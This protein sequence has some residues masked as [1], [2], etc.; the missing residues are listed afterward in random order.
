MEE[1][2]MFK[3]MLYISLLSGISLSCFSF[4]EVNFLKKEERKVDV[5]VV[6]DNQYENLIPW[7]DVCEGSNL[8]SSD[9]T[10]ALIYAA[11][12][13]TLS[14]S[15]NRREGI[16]YILQTYDVPRIER[17]QMRAYLDRKIDIH[18]IESFH[19]LF[20]ERARHFGF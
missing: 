9:A 1:F 10:A 14:D 16:R 17:E 3:K 8:L 11:Y 5:K 7:G 4:E 20:L 13:T 12:L 19:R 18:G 2:N 6:I 15:N